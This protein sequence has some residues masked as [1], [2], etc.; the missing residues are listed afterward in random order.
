[1]A[2]YTLTDIDG[3]ITE[4]E[5]KLRELKTA[6]L[7]GVTLQSGVTVFRMMNVVQNIGMFYLLRF[8]QDGHGC[9]IQRNPLT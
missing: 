1:M 3:R 5:N 4:Y 6:F 9:G 2:K 7:E 8:R